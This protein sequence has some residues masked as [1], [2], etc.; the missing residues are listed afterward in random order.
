M[1]YP[2]PNFVI[3]EAYFH[4]FGVVRVLCAACLAVKGWKVGKYA[5]RCGYGVQYCVRC[6]KRWSASYESRVAETG[7]G[8]AGCTGELGERGEEKADLPV[9]M[10]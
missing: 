8:T 7:T 10:A 9:C 5:T 3:S 2:K 6:E 4:G 1:V